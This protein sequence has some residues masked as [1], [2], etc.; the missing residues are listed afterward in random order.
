MLN[1]SRNIGI[2][3]VF[4]AVISNSEDFYCFSFS[5]S[6]SLCLSASLFYMRVN[7]FI[8]I[9]VREMDFYREYSVTQRERESIECTA[10][11]WGMTEEYIYRR[12]MGGTIGIWE[13]EASSLISY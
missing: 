11:L 4:G 13:R 8:Y 9:F 6:L 5:L 1:G 7:E 3:C 2:L 10:Q 12:K